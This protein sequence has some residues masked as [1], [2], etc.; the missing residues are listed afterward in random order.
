MCAHRLAQNEHLPL[1]K[2]AFHEKGNKLN[3]PASSALRQAMSIF[4]Q[5]PTVSPPP[6]SPLHPPTCSRITSSTTAAATADSRSCS[7]AA[8][9]GAPARTRTSAGGGAIAG[10]QDGEEASGGELFLELSPLLWRAKQWW[11]WLALAA[12]GWRFWGGGGEGSGNRRTLRGWSAYSQSLE[13]LGR[14]N[15]GGLF[16]LFF[17]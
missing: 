15:M 8:A 9:I 13:K 12:A 3:S 7:C 16:G 14:L 17:A 11:W 2:T 10:R 4:L 5:D 6:P 1:I